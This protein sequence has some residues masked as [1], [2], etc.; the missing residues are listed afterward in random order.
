MITVWHGLYSLVLVFPWLRIDAL[1]LSV[2]GKYRVSVYKQ[3]FLSREPENSVKYISVTID[4]IFTVKICLTSNF[5]TGQGQL[6]ENMHIVQSAYGNSY[7]MAIVKF[8]LFLSSFMLF[9]VKMCTKM[10]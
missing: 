6:N 5:E 9:T 1:P 10:T 7:F 2:Q 4:Y 3:F 8:V